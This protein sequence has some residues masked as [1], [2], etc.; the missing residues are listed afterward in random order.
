M[1]GM[2]DPAT[3]LRHGSRGTD[4]GKDRCSHQDYDGQY[5][6]HRDAQRTMVGITL[7]RMSVHNLRNG[8]QHEQEQANDRRYS[9][10]VSLGAAL[11]PQ[12]CSRS[13]QRYILNRIVH[14]FPMNRKACQN[15]ILA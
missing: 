9:Q 1:P 6:M 10:H 8:E 2:D 5:G 3:F 14:G 12:I 7:N 13:C 15:S 4:P 11:G